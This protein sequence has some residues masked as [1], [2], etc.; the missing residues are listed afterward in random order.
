MTRPTAV[1]SPSKTACRF[2]LNRFA[3]GAP[4]Q[5]ELAGTFA[6]LEEPPADLPVLILSGP[7]G[8][9][10]LPAAAGD[11][12]GAPENGQPWRAAF[13]WQ[14]APAPFESAV[15][16]LGS[17]LAVDLPEPR[18]NGAAPANM[19]LPVRVPPPDEDAPGSGFDRLRHD[20]DLIAAREELQEVKSA[21]RRTEGELRRAR[22]DLDS[23]RAERVA[24]AVRFRDGLATVRESAEHALAQEERTTQELRDELAAAHEA[25]AAKEAELADARGELDV[26]SAFRAEAETVAKAELAAVHERLDEA[27]CRIEIARNA[28]QD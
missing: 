20:A 9:Y 23:E 11:V 10:R 8:T 15:L 2:V 12:S 27:R 3:W 21:L 22:E 26:A 25:V 13:V 14:E 17:E 4:D 19:E 16:Q 7:D 24:D 28:L 6:G 5:L 18:D 1:T